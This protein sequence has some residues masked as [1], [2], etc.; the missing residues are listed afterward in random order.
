MTHEWSRALVQRRGRLDK[1]VRFGRTI[2][3]RANE[4]YVRA[5]RSG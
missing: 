2:A 4:A 5:A 3:E 1:H